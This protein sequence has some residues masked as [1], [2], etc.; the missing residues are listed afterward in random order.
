MLAFYATVSAFLIVLGSVKA[1]AND[2]NGISGQN[3]IS[4]DK[5]VSQLR[6]KGY[7]LNCEWDSNNIP[8]MDMKPDSRDIL[9]GNVSSLAIK[10]KCQLVR[11]AGDRICIVPQELLNEHSGD[12]LNGQI[13]DFHAENIG[14]DDLVYR[15]AKTAGVRVVI[16]DVNSSPVDKIVFNRIDFKECSLRDALNEIVQKGSISYWNA[17]V[18]FGEGPQHLPFALIQ[19]VAFPAWVKPM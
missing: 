5:I 9:T 4:L 2:A 8:G 15:L 6:D 3:H 12:P 17:N 19:F 14:L 13:P 10:L 11:Y 18:A 16:A 7:K 1:I